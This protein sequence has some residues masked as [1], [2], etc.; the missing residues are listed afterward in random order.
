MT[1]IIIPSTPSGAGVTFRDYWMDLASELGFI[2]QT[3]ITQ[4]ATYGEGRRTVIVD[5]MGD[6]EW[7]EDA[8]GDSWWCYVLSG[9]EAG[10]QRR[11]M[12]RGYLGND[13][14]MLL[15]RP[16]DTALGGDDIVVFTHPLPV[17]RTLAV[18]GLKTLSNE[19]LRNTRVLARLGLTGDGTRS[20][21]LGDYASF[22]HSEE[23]I[24]AV[25]DSNLYGTDAPL[26]S[27]AYGWRLA[28]DSPTPTLVTDYTYA[29]GTAFALEVMAPGDRLIYDGSDWGYAAAPGLVDDTDQAAAPLHWVRAFAMVKGLAELRKMARRIPD[30][31]ERRARIQELDREA[32][33]WANRAV[34]IALEE[35]PQPLQKPSSGLF[36]RAYQTWPDPIST[37]P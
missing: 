8:Y 31:A 26:S 19:G 29:D 30:A 5:E 3:T 12:S 24:R 16:F 10:Q 18:K 9:A 17:V 4:S 15:S 14:A 34:R 22:I 27:T 7:G 28:V 21:D 2:H 23:D 20:F 6:D 32:R 37:W 36:G 13:R 35:M 1:V 11:V 33:T 25:Y